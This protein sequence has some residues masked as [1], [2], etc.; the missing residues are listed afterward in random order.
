MSIG[1]PSMIQI[2]VYKELEE[3]VCILLLYH[4]TPVYTIVYFFVVSTDVGGSKKPTIGERQF[5]TE[6]I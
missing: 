1:S 6:D 5:A 3:Q 4:C 2:D